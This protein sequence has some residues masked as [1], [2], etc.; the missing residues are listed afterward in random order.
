[1]LIGH[2]PGLRHFCLT[3][4]E[5]GDADAMAH[6]ELKFPTS[7]LAVIDCDCDSWDAIRPDIGY[8]KAYWDRHQV[9]EAL[10]A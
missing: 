7:A 8:L 9:K 2:N 4:A 10:A 6:A 3:L 1:M 5:S